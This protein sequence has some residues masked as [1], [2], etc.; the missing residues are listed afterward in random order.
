M[1]TIEIKNLSFGYTDE[2]LFDQAEIKI[3]KKWKLGLVGRNGRGKTTLLKLLSGQVKADSFKQDGSSFVYFPEAFDDLSVL[4]LYLLQEK[5]NFEQWE[6]ERELRLLQVD[7]DVLWRPF[8]TLSGG[9]QTKCLLALLFLT[10]DSFALIDEPTNHLDHTSRQIVATYLKKK[11]GFI[12]VS[13][14]SSFLDAVCDHILA[15]E[16]EKI[17]LYQG[18]FS[19]YDTQKKLQD[20]TEKAADDKLSQQISRLKKTARDKEDWAKRREGDIHGNPQIKNSGG[21]G[22]D[23]GITARAARVMKRS[24]SLEKRMNQE[25]ESKEKLVKNIEQIDDL[26]LLMKDDHHQRLLSCE[27]VSLSY[28]QPLFEP[29]SFDIKK[30]ER[31][32]IAGDN[33]SGKSSFIKALQGQFEGQISGKIQLPHSSIAV[34]CV[35]QIFDNRGNLRDFAVENELDVELFLS[36]LRKLGMERR[37][38]DQKIEQMS[39]GQQKKVE[40]ARSLS[41]EASFYIWDEP[42]NYLDLYNQEQLIKLIGDRQPT[43]L[44]VEHDARFIKAIDAKIINLIKG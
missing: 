20:K 32:V 41:Q 29:V 15:I 36:N 22:H 27:N 17:S 44:I 31:V 18:N 30:G 10:P 8:D 35:R 1:T 12:L 24:K 37:V 13:H 33:G 28:D 42:L 25:I 39:Q 21:I 7:V 5:A 6:L 14:D 34:S 19:T 23:G 26:A 40:L 16:R 43:M 11:S 3:D 38:F 9:E 2:L 4:T